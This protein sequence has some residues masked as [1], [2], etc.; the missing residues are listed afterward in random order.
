MERI[1]AI[2]KM[3]DRNR[4]VPFQKFLDAFEVSRP[5]IKRDL[6]YMRDRLG[7]PIEYDREQGGYRYRQPEGTDGGDPAENF[8]YQLPGVWL[9][10]SEMHA[11]LLMYDL[12]SQL[13]SRVLEGA[14]APAARRIESL[15]SGG[16]AKPK[17]IRRRF[18]IIA[19]RHRPVDEQIFRI[20]ST[21]VLQRK[22]LNLTYFSRSRGEIMARTVS[23]QRLIWYSSNWYLDAWCHTREDFRS[24]SL[25]AIRGA[26]LL[27]EKADD[28]PQ[29]ILDE[30]LGA[31]YGI[32]AGPPGETAV[33]RFG[34]PASRWI[35]REVWHPD[36][37][38][39]PL[40]GGEVRLEVPYSDPREL[41]QDILRFVPHVVVE[42][43]E[44]LRQIV[45][46]QLESGLAA[47]RGEQ[48]KPAAAEA[49]LTAV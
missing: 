46:G 45:I 25:D 40:P 1:V 31:G 18:R 35:E 12:L 7:A 43:P 29:E 14:L 13:D 33:L 24:F 19:A 6:Q 11:L 30:R 23:P 10:S 5:T 44:S 20:V 47:H 15:L 38:L 21:G 37:R 22:R 28:Y 8:R 32:F 4:A 48:R 26:S 41:A 16:K 2:H 42:G 39:T 3:L 49:R 34:L 17:D 27:S 36:Q 9:N